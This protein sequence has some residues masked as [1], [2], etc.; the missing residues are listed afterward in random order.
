M[1]TPSSQSS[2]IKVSYA[3]FYCACLNTCS[4]SY[5]L[6]TWFLFARLGE[7]PRTPSRDAPPNRRVMSL[8]RYRLVLRRHLL[9]EQSI[10]GLVGHHKRNAGTGTLQLN[11]AHSQDARSLLFLYNYCYIIFSPMKTKQT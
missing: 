10:T 4:L 9:A 8:S 1:K 6:R 11:G 3:R 5:I 2:Y 7:S